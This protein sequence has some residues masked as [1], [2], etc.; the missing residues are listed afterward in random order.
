MALRPDLPKP[1]VQLV[2]RALS[3]DPAHRPSAGDLGRALRGAA[4]PRRKT[5]SRSRSSVV[6]PAEAARFGSAALAATFAGW[7]ATALPFFPHGWAAGLAL[8]AA[9]ATAFRPRLG[10]A[11][12]LAVPVLPLGNVSLGLAVLYAAIAAA[13]LALSWR[14]PRAGLL[15]AVGPAL[16]PIAALGLLPLATSWLRSAPRR[17]AHAAVAVLVAGVV[18]G[19][20]GVSLPFTGESPPL[21]VGV[22]GAVDPFDVAGSLARAATAHPGLLLEALALAAVAVALPFARRH[23]LWGAALLGSGMLLTT[24]LVAPAAA[25]APLVA[26]AWITAGFSALKRGSAG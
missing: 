24:L 11:A 3:V 2:D 8:G 17:A 16:A 13:W 14:E 7:T 23:G 9:A 6:V 22:A 26:A 19:I 4:E 10:L 5:K 18:A 25:A 12:A 21:G 20:R 15:F 1:L